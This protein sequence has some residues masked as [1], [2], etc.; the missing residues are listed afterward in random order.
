MSSTPQNETVR[1]FWHTVEKII[2]AVVFVD[3]S[4]PSM[5]SLYVIESDHYI[6]RRVFFLFSPNTISPPFLHRFSRKVATRRVH[7]Q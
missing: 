6:L 7:S 5:V 1:Q 2:K 4:F 3:S